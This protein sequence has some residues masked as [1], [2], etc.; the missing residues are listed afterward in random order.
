MS[1]ELAGVGIGLVSVPRFR[2]ALDRFGP[3]LAERVFSPAELAY[4][5]RKRSAA[6]SLAGRF[7]AKCAGRRALGWRV[8][9]RDLEVVRRR[10]GEPTL[11]IGSGARARFG[12]EVPRLL[13]SLT[14]DSEFALASVWV[15]RRSEPG[16]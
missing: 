4:A 10:S 3:R 8:A 1:A 11:E 2:A 14:H 9:L 16:C 12:P 6:H 7:A 15:E 13:L 5:T